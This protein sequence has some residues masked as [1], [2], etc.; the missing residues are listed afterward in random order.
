MGTEDARSAVRSYGPPRS[1]SYACMPPDADRRVPDLSQ[2][3]A[4]R[5]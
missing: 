4:A 3:P 2:S 1:R 5:L